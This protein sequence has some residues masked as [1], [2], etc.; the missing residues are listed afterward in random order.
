MS[1]FE[2]SPD[3]SHGKICFIALGAYPL[4]TGRTSETIIGPD[5]HQVLLGRELVKK[6]F[7]VAFIVLTDEESGIERRDGIEIIKLMVT[8]SRIR[9]VTYF[10]KV[11]GL[12]YALRKAN[13]DMYFQQGGWLG[14][15]SPFCRITRKKFV[16][17]VGSDAQVCRDL[18][19]KHMKEFHKSRLSAGYLGNWLD[20]MLADLVIVQNDFQ[21]LMLKQNFRRDGRLVKMPLAPHHYCMPEKPDP[22]MVLW[23]GSLAEVKQPEVFLDLAKAIP[24]ASFVMVGG[25]AGNA[26]IYD[27]IVLAS[28][29]LSNFQY[30][31]V[32]PFQDMYRY[33]RSASLLVNTSMFEGFPHAFLEAWMHS[34][35]V[36]SLNS[37]PDELICRYKMGLHSQNYTQLVEDVRLLL[38]DEPL[39]KE[40]GMNGRKYVK[41]QHDLLR[42]IDTYVE[43]FSQIRHPRRHEIEARDG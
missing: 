42:I 28:K 41:D 1:G 11:L 10:M 26:D 7:D 40:M 19:R 12:W 33:F 30:M 34:V 39:R 31:G 35:P 27:K 22:P 38:T 9:F 14:V 25:S 4:L 36:V 13:A 17:S 37:D 16:N 18:V 43:I 23:V 15:V 3:K 21:L 20:I 8:P 5:I 2:E 6:G 29:D 24:T 32:V